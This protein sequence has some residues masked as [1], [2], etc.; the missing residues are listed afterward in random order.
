M[1]LC[2]SLRASDALW[3][4]R[5]QPTRL[6]CPWDSPD[7]KTGVDCHFLLQG[8]FLT[9]GLNPGLLHCRWSLY[10]LRHQGLPIMFIYI[11]YLYMMYIY[12]CKMLM[13]KQDLNHFA[14]YQKWT[15]HRKW[16]NFNKINLNN[17]KPTFK[18]DLMF[19]FET[20]NSFYTIQLHS[21]QHPLLYLLKHTLVWF[22]GSYPLPTSNPE[23]SGKE[24]VPG[25]RPRLCWLSGG[26][27]SW[28]AQPR[29]ARLASQVS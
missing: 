12:I 7:E 16:T 29:P 9:Q 10:H 1:C 28:E 14:V 22:W 4:H 25:S 13:K 21:V 2:E 17:K 3:P 23:P 18:Y 19:P 24:Q 20:M 15:Q 11:I 26:Q 5:L 27:V 6:L 8:S